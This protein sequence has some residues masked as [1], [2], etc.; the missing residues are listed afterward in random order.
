LL[1]EI[2]FEGIPVV[3]KL[4]SHGDLPSAFRNEIAE[5]LNK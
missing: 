2:A 3:T 5:F 1:F 4:A